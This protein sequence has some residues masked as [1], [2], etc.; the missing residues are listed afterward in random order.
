[1]VEEEEEMEEKNKR[2]ICSK[3]CYPVHSPSPNS[4]GAD[5]SIYC[6]F[7]ILEI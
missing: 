5:Y 7:P 3:Y 1:M 4:L 6:L 2:T